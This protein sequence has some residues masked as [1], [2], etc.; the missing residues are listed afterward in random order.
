MF[1]SESG[2]LWISGGFKVGFGGFSAIL[3]LQPSSVDDADVEWIAGENGV[4][5]CSPLYGLDMFFETM[6]ILSAS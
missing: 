3:I 1:R 5:S 2:T 4:V 6:M